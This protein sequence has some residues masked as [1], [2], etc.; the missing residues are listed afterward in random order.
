MVFRPPRV[1][2][3][4]KNTDGCGLKGGDKKERG[5][6]YFFPLRPQGARVTNSSAAVGCRAT[7]L[8]KSAFFAFILTATAKPCA[9]TNTRHTC[10]VLNQS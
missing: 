2:G 5:V 8:S 4:H 9:G 6:V 10:Q 1:R 7:Q 3:S